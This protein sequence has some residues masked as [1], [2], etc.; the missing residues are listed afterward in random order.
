MSD[1]CRTGAD[2]WGHDRQ[3]KAFGKEKLIWRD[4]TCVE[5]GRFQINESI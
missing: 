3:Q 2:A 5:D 4:Y 1:E